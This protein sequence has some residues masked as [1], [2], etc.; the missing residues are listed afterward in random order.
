MIKK[1]ARAGAVLAMVV[2]GTVAVAAPAHAASGG[3]CT[4]GYPISACI[5]ASGSLAR[6]DFYMNATPDSGWCRAYIELRFTT[7]IG[8]FTSGTWYLYRGGPFG[9]L[10]H[11]Y[12]TVPPKAG[13]VVNVVHMLT[14]NGS[15]NGTYTSPRLYF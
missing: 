13:S 5:S 7:G 9:P 12:T 8:P 3:G 10:S 11:D 1:L 2:V 14:C 15:P 4:G 6:A